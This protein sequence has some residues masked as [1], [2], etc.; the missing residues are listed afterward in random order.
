MVRVLV[1]GA[2]LLGLPAGL[3]GCEPTCKQT[4]RKLVSCETESDRV[5]VEEC[6]SAC[7]LQERELEETEQDARRKALADHK[8]CI[9]SES[10]DDVVAGVCLDTD[11]APF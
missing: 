6:E 7:V 5:T 2:L 9:R 10:C 4:C 1:V 3:A 8:R 11:L